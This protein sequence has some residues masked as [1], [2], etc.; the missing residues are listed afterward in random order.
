MNY[1]S[2]I[3]NWPKPKRRKRKRKYKRTFTPVRRNQAKLLNGAMI[4]I[5]QLCD[6]LDQTLEIHAP[7]SEPARKQIIDVRNMAIGLIDHAAGFPLATPVEQASQ[8]TEIVQ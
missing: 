3:L 2:G 6:V 5:G 8:P 1:L 4:L 7:G